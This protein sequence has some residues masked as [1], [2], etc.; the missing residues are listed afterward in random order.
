MVMTDKFW[1]VLMAALCLVFGLAKAL[2]P[3]VFLALRQRYSWYNLFDIYSSIFKSAY[4]EQAVRI[5]GY[6]L[7]LIGIGL[8]AWA[9]FK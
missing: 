2:R 3:Q 8:I 7:V 9:I 1:V 4:A 6:L 5:N